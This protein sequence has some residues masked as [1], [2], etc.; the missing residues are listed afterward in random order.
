MLA[1]LIDKKPQQACLYALACALCTLFGLMHSVLPSGEVYLPWAP[2]TLQ[3]YEIAFSYLLLA[4][5]FLLRN[6]KIA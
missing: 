4:G 2:A 1:L 5:I 6:K 3:H